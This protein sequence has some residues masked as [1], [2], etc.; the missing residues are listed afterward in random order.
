[1][2]HFHCDEEALAWRII[3]QVARMCIEL[4]LH[5]RDSLFKVVTDEQER[6][7]A[8]KMFWAIYVLDRR[9]SFGTGMPF[10]LQDADIDPGLP[11]PVSLPRIA[12]NITPLINVG[13][14]HSLPQRDDILLPHRLESLALCLHLLTYSNT[15]CKHRRHRLSRLPNHPMAKVDP[16]RTPTPHRL[17]P[18]NLFPRHPPSANPTL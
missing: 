2:Y 17:I 3:G 10:A 18:A 15:H 8:I 16:D 4:G 7:D 12:S 6:L 13:P 14:Q 1:M 11:E 9:W 5:R